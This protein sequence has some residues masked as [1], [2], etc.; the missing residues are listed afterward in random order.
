MFEEGTA[1]VADPAATAPGSVDDTKP[2]GVF[3]MEEADCLKKFM[4]WWREGTT[5][6]VETRKKRK[7]DWQF[8]GGDQWEQSDVE[9][10][11]NK[12]RPQ[13]T[14]N[15][16]LS[17]I[18]AVEG[19]ERTNRQEMKFW[20]EGQE[21]DPAAY[22]INRLVKWIMDQC[23]GQFSLSKAFRS[24]IVCGEGWVVPEVDYF[25]DP[26]GKIKVL[27]V[28][29]EEMVPDPLDTTETAKGGRYLHRARMYSE[30]E[31][32]AR[33]P[34][35]CQK[36]KQVSIAAGL[37][38]ETDG[39]GLRD[40]YT[41]TG[42]P[43]SPKLYDAQRKM[44]AVIET[45]WTQIEQ[46]WI[47]VDEKT[48]LLVE[49]SD[50]EFQ[51]MKAQRQQE[52]AAWLQTAMQP[53]PMVAAAP[54]APVGVG[55]APVAPAPAGQPMPFAHA[56]MAAPMVP[57]P[58]PPMPPALQAT[59]RA[60]R[61]FYQAFWCAGTILQ[62]QPSPL[63]KLKRFPYVPFRGL[64]DKVNKEWFGLTRPIIDPQRQHNVEQTMI[65]QLMQL[66]PKSSWMAPKG[67]FHDRQKW[68]TGLAKPGSLLEYNATRGK[69]EPIPVQAI[70]RHLIDMALQRPQTMR[71]ISGVNV[72]MTGQR[73]GSDPGVV[74]EQRQKAAKTVLAPM[75][76]N[77]RSSKMELGRVLL[78]YIQAYISVGRRIRVLGGKDQAYVVMTEDMQLGDYDLT[79]DETNETIN[80]RI[81]T[82][83]ILQTTLPTL[84]K[85][86]V[87]VPP[88][89]VDM[90]PM[91]PEVKQ[92]WKRLIEWQMQINGMLPPPGWQPGMPVPTP[93]ALAP[94]PGAAPPLVAAPPPPPNTA[95][96]SPPPP[97]P[98]Q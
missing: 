40:I 73:Q 58:L 47:V 29:D 13:L 14:L 70:P 79:V 95:A 63:T 20:G 78:A 6:L 22:G 84:M 34:G 19:E 33:W 74:M 69:P 4:E 30:E 1:N 37:A 75:F 42:D 41:I 50:D 46:G 44:W 3:Q 93:G 64:F 39:A 9:D 43:K 66:Q 52:Q 15:M 26:N 23:G 12:K 51:Q 38:T 55:G 32:E 31:G 2:V 56:A 59:Q 92:D 77:N 17:I 49:K 68:E 8:Y 83:N 97:P 21:D 16:V 10:A 71:E 57:A 76:D 11:K 94:P 62:R 54:P 81:A 88:S 5:A 28:D 82:L 96:P 80:D 7:K 85:A 53:R 48:Q 61:R 72:E 98:A 87:P 67:A 36:V 24:E 45:W 35:F 65:M 60:I 91:P 90:M 86:G 89:F 18:S 27:D 25:D